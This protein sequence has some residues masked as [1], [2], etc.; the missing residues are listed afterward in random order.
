MVGIGFRV[1][2]YDKLQDVA[3]EIKTLHEV[4]SSN[5]VFGVKYTIEEKVLHH[6]YHLIS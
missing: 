2:P 6:S 4:Y 1:D 3:K 5:P